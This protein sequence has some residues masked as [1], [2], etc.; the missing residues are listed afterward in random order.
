MTGEVPEILRLY[1]NHHI[2]FDSLEDRLLPFALDP[3]CEDERDMVDLVF[4]E[5]YSVRDGTSSEPLF[6][7]RIA[8]LIAPEPNRA[9]V[10]PSKATAI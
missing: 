3:Q 10:T 9:R 5:F 2:D 4:A 1:L 8:Q 6:K 7:E